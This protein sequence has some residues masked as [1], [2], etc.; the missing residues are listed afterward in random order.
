MSKKLSER[1]KTSQLNQDRLDA[2]YRLARACGCDTEQAKAHAVGA[3]ERICQGGEMDYRNKIRAIRKG[4][5]K[6]GVQTAQTYDRLMT[7]YEPQPLTA[8][9]L[10]PWGSVEA[11]QEELDLFDLAKPLP[12]RF[13][14]YSGC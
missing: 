7:G 10:C 14:R 3:V 8:E 12:A 11:G 9:R 6:P 2:V 1:K 5:A 4:T 13:D